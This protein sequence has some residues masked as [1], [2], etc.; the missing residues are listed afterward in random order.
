M[1]TTETL[2]EEAQHAQVAQLQAKSTR[3]RRLSIRCVCVLECAHVP[4]E[5]LCRVHPALT[6]GEEKVLLH[7]FVVCAQEE[8]GNSERVRVWLVGLAV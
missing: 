7:D 2:R 4:E 5:R 3:K 1:G 6:H 8:R